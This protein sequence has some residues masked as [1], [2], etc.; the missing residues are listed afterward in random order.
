MADHPKL[1]NPLGRALVATSGINPQQRW[2]DY[3]RVFIEGKGKS[4]GKRKKRKGEI[5][6]KL[7]EGEKVARRASDV[8]EGMLKEEMALA[9]EWMMGRQV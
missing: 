1:L 7:E 8:I 3:M 6:G 5:E 9:M 2:R 4:E